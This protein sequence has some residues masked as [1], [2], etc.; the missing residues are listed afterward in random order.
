MSHLGINLNIPQK[1]K[2]GFFIRNHSWTATSPSSYLW[3]QPSQTLLQGPQQMFCHMV[4]PLQVLDCIW[5][6]MAHTQKPDF[7]FRRN[8][9]VHLNQ[10]GRKFNR[11][12]AAE[13]CASAVVMLDTLCSEVVSGVLA[14][15]SICQFPLHFPSSA[16][17][18]A[19]TFQLESTSHLKKK[20]FPKLFCSQ[21][22]LT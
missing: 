22:L 19:I 14:T 2:S 11:L 9:L 20:V 6:V 13:V 5:N 10:R 15:N 12:L 21:T 17:P 18:C 1:Q 16:S 4:P 7:V 3:N 8:G